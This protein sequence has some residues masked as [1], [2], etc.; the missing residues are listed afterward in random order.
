MEKGRKR[1]RGRER[2]K[3][4]RRRRK[5]KKKLVTRVFIDVLYMRKYHQLEGKRAV[6]CLLCLL[7]V[8]K[9]LS[10]YTAATAMAYNFYTNGRIILFL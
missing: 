1:V 3:G 10:M 5:K 2:R 8:H 9:L 6:D 7:S 4:R